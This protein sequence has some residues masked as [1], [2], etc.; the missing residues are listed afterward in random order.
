MSVNRS[1]ARDVLL[2]VLMLAGAW[3][4]FSHPVQ[5]INASEKFNLAAAIPESFAGWSSRTQDTSNY[6]DRWNSINEVLVRHY[7]KEN[8]FSLRNAGLMGVG[9]VLEYSSDLR[10]NF[11]FHFP[12]NCHRAGGNE[13]EFLSPMEVPLSEGKSLVAK[14][15]FIKG[16]PGSAENVDKLVTYWLVVDGKQRYRTF[17]IKLD[18]M[19]SG[20]LSR[21]KKGFLV[22]I[23]YTSGLEYTPEGLDK[24][25]RVTAGFIGDLYFSLD[26]EKKKLLFGAKLA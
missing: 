7:F 12:E 9:F 1:H 20:L 6:Q 10:Q 8:I 16:I 17:F 14:R 24:A 19:L 26:P 25:S 2:M 13:V 3:F 4:V 21:S 11:G 5:K 18:Q 15:I 23:D 22:R